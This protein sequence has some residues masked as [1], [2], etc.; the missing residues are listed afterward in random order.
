M[1]YNDILDYGKCLVEFEKRQGEKN[2]S[3]TGG[4]ESLQARKERV[5]QSLKDW[6]KLW[7]TFLENGKC[8]LVRSYTGSRN[9]KVSILLG[10]NSM[11]GRESKTVGHEL[12]R[13]SRVSLYRA[14]IWDPG[15]YVLLYIC[16]HVC[17]LVIS[18]GV[19]VEDWGLA[20]IFGKKGDLQDFSQAVSVSSHSGISFLL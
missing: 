19:V 20:R 17:V 6:E 5:S 14:S 18:M 7:I 9:I 11:L 2:I 10:K 12:E 4:W 15:G 16:V 8:K 1:F 13:Q 3:Q